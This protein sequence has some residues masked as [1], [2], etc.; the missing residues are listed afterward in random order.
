[1]VAKLYTPLTLVWFQKF[2][3]TQWNPLHC[4]L[5]CL[6][7]IYIARERWESVNWEVQHINQFLVKLHY[8]QFVFIENCIYVK[9]KKSIKDQRNFCSNTF[10]KCSPTLWVLILRYDICAYFTNR[11][12]SI[13]SLPQLAIFLKLKNVYIWQLQWSAI[14]SK[15]IF[16][17]LIQLSLIHISEPTRQEAIS[18]AVFCLKKKK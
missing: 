11:M 10:L 9:Q 7:G 8:F 1:M 14:H 6:W 17:F 13:S 3:A 16:C 4:G 12:I 2:L 18:Y 15:Y 5:V